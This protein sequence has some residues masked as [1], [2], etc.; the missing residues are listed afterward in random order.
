[1]NN[2]LLA[3]LPDIPYMSVIALVL[4]AFPVLSL[5]VLVGRV[6]WLLVLDW[7]RSSGRRAQL[8]AEAAELTRYA[9]EVTVAA[10][11][12]AATAERHRQY[13]LTAV[14]GTEESGRALDA[15]EAKLRRLAAAAAFPVPQTRRTPVEYAD[16]EQY[17]HR[18]AMAACMRRELSIYQLSDALA[19]RNGWDPRLHP[20][21]QELML[22]RAARDHLAA[23]RAT[24]IERERAAWQTAQTAVVAAR[25]LRDEAL[26]AAWHAQRLRPWLRPSPQAL[27]DTSDAVTQVLPMA[28]PALQWQP[29][30]AR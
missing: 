17:L 2:L 29:A 18:A 1:M 24:A 6:G 8:A 4:V 13:W 11:R 21:C 30:H 20:A 23:T 14:A 27:A 7:I 22:G 12:A 3:V 19:H 16:R 5:A 15:A 10:Q 25:S 26:T 28:R 9:G